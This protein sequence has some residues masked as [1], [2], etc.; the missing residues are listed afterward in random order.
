M[1]DPKNPLGGSTPDDF[2]A[3][4][5][6]LGGEPPEEAQDDRPAPSNELPRTTGPIYQPPRA[7]APPPAAAPDAEL[8]SIFDDDE[9]DV[10]T[11]MVEAEEIKRQAGEGESAK[12]SGLGAVFAPRPSAPGITAAPPPPPVDEEIPEVLSVPPPPPA[13]DDLSDPFAELEASAPKPVAR[14]APAA[15]PMPTIPRAPLTPGAMPPKPP[16][17]AGMPPRPPIPGGMPPRVPIGAGG[18]PPPPPRMALP[19]PGM[20]APPKPGGAGVNLPRPPGMPGAVRPPS[21]PAEA[22]PPA[23]IESAP[24]VESK[25]AQ[26]VASV[27]PIAV[28]A[29]IESPELAEL[30]AL[31]DLDARRSE[32]IIAQAKATT[33]PPA[34]EPRTAPPPAA[35]ED[36]EAELSLE[37]GNSVP[38]ASNEGA[39]IDISSPPD[40]SPTTPPAAS[41]DEDEGPA[42]E[43]AVETTETSEEEAP[44]IASSEEED[45]GP[46]LEAAGDD[47]GPVFETEEGE[48]AVL[49][50]GDDAEVEAPRR[51]E[52]DRG[53]LLAATVTSRKRWLEPAEIAYAGD[54]RAEVEARAGLLE[55]EA[56]FADTPARTAEMLTLA[57]EMI[58][59]VV[60]DRLRAKSLYERA[61]ESDPNA[62]FAIRA[63]RR[64]ALLDDDVALAR[65]LTERERALPLSE[66]DRI[67]VDAFAAE[68]EARESQSSA[69]AIWESQSSVAGVRGAVAKLLDGGSRR[70]AATMGLALESIGSTASGVFGAAAN[71]A[72]ARLAERDVQNDTALNAVQAAVQ[73]DPTDVTSWLAMARIAISRENAPVFRDALGGLARTGTGSAAGWAATALD[74]ATG[75]ILGAPIGSA[76]V[77]SGGPG[78]WLVAHA[79]RDSGIDEMPQVTASLETATDSQKA[80]W[81]LLTEEGAAA[82]TSDVGR[83]MVLRRAVAA[84]DA[85]RTAAA[86]ANLLGGDDAARAGAHAAL[87]ATKD[88]VSASEVAA[89]SVG[90][91]FRMPELASALIAVSAGADA[92]E[93]K[94]PPRVEGAFE[95]I[96]ATERTLRDDGNSET[97]MTNFAAA[98]DAEGHD[99]ARLYAA[100]A[101]ARSSGELATYAETLATE[102]ALAP[103]AKRAAGLRFLRGAIGA[104][105]AL[106]GAAH[107]ALDAARALKGDLPSAELTALFGLRGEVS[108]ADSSE[109][110]TAAAADATTLA[111]QMAAVRASLRLAATEPEAAAQALYKAWSRVKQDGVLSALVLRAL[112]HDDID[113]RDAIMRDAAERSEAAGPVAGVTAWTLVAQALSD[114]GRPGDAA[115]ALARARSFDANDPA[116]VAWEE[117]LW[118]SS[119]MFSEVAE[120]SFDA[121]KSATNDEQRIAAYER[122]AELDSA[123]RNDVASAVLT[124]QAILELAPGHMAS[125]RTL[126]RYFLEQGRYEELLG[127]YDRLIRHV[128]DPADATAIAHAAARIAIEQAEND[129]SAGAPFWAA[130]FERGA[131]DLRTVVALDAEARRGGDLTRFAAVMERGESLATEPRERATYAL[132]AAEAHIGLGQFERAAESLARAREAYPAHPVAHA[133]TAYLREH[134]SD[135]AGAAEAYEALARVTKVPPHAVAALLKAAILWQDKTDN[136]ERARTTL[137]EVLTRDPSNADAFQ[138]S[139]RVMKDQGDKQS[140]LDVLE[141]RIKAGGTPND[142]LP[143]HLRMAEVAEEIGDLTRARNALR[144]VIAVE[145]DRQDALRVL[146][147]LSRTTQDWAA[148]ADAMIKLARLSQDAN[149]RNELMYGLGEIFDQHL[150]DPRRAEAAYKRVLQFLPNDVR[151]LTRIAD[152]YA[153]ANN[154]AAEAETLRTLVAATPASAT[155]RGLQIRL[156]AVLSEKLEEGKKAEEV[157]EAARRDA[158]T[159]M[160]VLRAF[161][162]LYVRQEAPMALAVLLDRAAGEVRRVL[163][164]DLT[165]STQFELLTDILKLRGRVD[166]ARVVGAVAQGLGVGTEKLAALSREGTVPGAGANVLTVDVMD[167]LA[168]PTVT[169]AHRELFRLSA[170][171]LEKLIPFDLAAVRA[172]KLGARPH[173][174]RAEIERVAK[175]F[176]LESIEILIGPAT[177]LIVTPIGRHPPTVMI[178]IDLAN[179][180]ASRFAIVRALAIVAL[181]LPI[182]VRVPAREMTIVLAGLL[183]QFEPMFMPDGSDPARVDEMGKRILRIYPRQRHAE[184]NPHAFEVIGS[185]NTDGDGLAAGVVELA[186]RLAMLA[187]GDVKGG[188]EALT[189]QGATP[190]AAVATAPALGRLVRVAISDRFMEA[191]HVTGAD[192]RNSST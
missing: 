80:A 147:R 153:R 180:P 127:I 121:L 55:G 173:P 4:L 128:G 144:A 66:T 140:E 137:R 107:E 7:S 116:L 67:E 163:D 25:P 28:P 161:A 99:A 138:R 91:A 17:G 160:D 165:N 24:V 149:E 118:L 174:M 94:V 79:M 9:V 35:D 48:E 105:L 63:L 42:L 92:A 71:L 64:I 1:T 101:I 151:T 40:A 85:T 16:I 181:S 29:P 56:Q 167:M 117:D 69:Q 87:L 61:L 141:G 84:G 23:V 72:R 178:P 38:P 3:L 187:S 88:T 33:P 50:V 11:R 93:A 124:Y 81:A 183:R 146:A 152:L 177:A 145:P 59:G 22:A 37:I 98:R 76:T 45:E 170:D 6:A 53:A 168:P 52:D 115:K 158:P 148:A 26:A 142:L 109:V 47:E 159:D 78:A 156:A 134:Q 171:V 190:K 123:F 13:P 139:L 102:T 112:P 75:S 120:R 131:S 172:E 73:R 125:L 58:E 96:A 189:P 106:E 2:D 10:P 126:E 113:H 89:L 132:R 82:N 119:G 185:K 133:W 60:G 150:N 164:A 97:A 191:R 57:G 74:A 155:R 14:T 143:L 135:F 166:G 46:A 30:L 41:T 5:D 114:A 31:D 8:S 108:P 27:P 20:P 188:I 43:A 32:E 110:L 104:G 77:P 162:R 65:E 175:L 176:G 95:S 68:L 15:P 19:R 103:E 49:E 182:A 90:D 192:K 122:L 39:D 154:A 83:F 86:A 184:T 111:Q 51:A 179:S 18:A 62:L 157:L 169:N 36:S 12:G 136:A 70:D 44:A 186:N 100:R 34:S 54:A 21:P 129:Q 130:A